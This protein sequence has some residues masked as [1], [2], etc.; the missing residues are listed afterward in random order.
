MSETDL[1]P[2]RRAADSARPAL[3]G[4]A[5]LVFVALL[6]NLRQ[7]VVLIGLAVLL[8]YA[9]DPLASSLERIRPRGRGLPRPFASAI[10]MLLI[11]V[12]AGFALAWIVPQAATELLRFVER[13]PGI[14]DN[15][16]AGVHEWANA[17]G[18]SEYADPAIVTLRSN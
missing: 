18:L 16:A 15:I 4:T 1:P 13:A 6:W 17:R 12:L 8:A 2:R 3:L 11:V 5:L 14:V 9:L 10:V 7:L